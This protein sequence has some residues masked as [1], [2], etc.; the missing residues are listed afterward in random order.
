[1]RWLIALLFVLIANVA[2]AQ[3]PEPGHVSTRLEPV[4]APQRIEA[5]PRPVPLLPP[6]PSLP[7]LDGNANT[8]LVSSL[9]DWELRI[10]SDIDA[11]VSAIP[12]IPFELQKVA[13]VL[14]DDAMSEGYA[15]L[16]ITLA[17]FGVAGMAA[18]LILRRRWWHHC[19]GLGEFV[20]I[21][22][23]SGVMVLFFFAIEWPPLVRDVVA[24]Y[25]GAFILYRILSTAIR[26]TTTTPV[27]RRL[28]L[29]A[30]LLLL[31]IATAGAGAVLTIDQ[32]VLQAI[33]YLVSAV[34]VALAFE[35][36]WSGLSWSAPIKVG[37]SF[38]V[39][40]VWLVWLAGSRSLFWIGIYAIVLPAVLHAVTHAVRNHLSTHLFIPPSDTRNVLAVRGSRAVIIALAAASISLIWEID[41][42]STGVGDA[43]VSAVFYGIL[44]S[45]MVLLLIDLAWH[46]AKAAIDRNFGSA[47]SNGTALAAHATRLGTLMPILRNMLAVLLFV[48]SGMIV[49]S[50]LGVEIGPLIAGAGIFGVAIGFGSQTL[51]KDV[52]SG[53]FYLFDDAFRVGEYIQAKEYEGTVEGFSLRSVRL[54]HSRG[55]IFTVPFGDL[56][57]VENMSRD[58]SKTKI[59]VTVPY[60]TDLEK[61]RKIGKAIGQILADDPEVSSLFIEPLKMKG[62]EE[63]GEYGVVV[64]FSMVTVPSAQQSFIRRTAYAMIRKSFQEN[65]IA[66][67]QPT[68]Q[69]G[70]DKG[71]QAAAAATQTQR[72]AG[73]KVEL[74]A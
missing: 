47:D 39:V 50:Q 22:I 73:A 42:H 45:V 38:Y 46:L 5:Q 4:P 11:V 6:D 52:I 53:F 26:L 51:V 48:I 55:P 70:G 20:P 72:N 9:T 43:R 60:D 13:L 3:L 30:G 27:H 71:A 29:T 1:M 64:S 61:V 18:E 74:G 17:V 21:S 14:H 16:S 65:G 23:F 7:S 40:G 58:W 2:A 31:A 35:F 37:L 24:C 12:R 8:S 54:R 56:G 28:R 19:G 57:A 63:F 10:R 15:W 33:F 25:L 69:V 67:A 34:A 44:K 68:I 62:V 32:H 41:A 59:K 49:L 66:F 36:I